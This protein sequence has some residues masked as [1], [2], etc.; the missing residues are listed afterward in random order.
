M[1]TFDDKTFEHMVKTR[2]KDT[3]HKGMVVGA[4]VACTVVLD[5]IDKTYQGSEDPDLEYLIEDIKNYCNR[6]L[7]VDVTSTVQN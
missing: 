5:M 3:Y 4:Q 6:E 7:K 1:N 2:L